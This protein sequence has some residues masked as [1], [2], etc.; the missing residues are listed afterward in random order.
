MTVSALT[1]TLLGDRGSVVSW[2]LAPIRWDH[3]HQRGAW[4]CNPELAWACWPRR[5]HK[6]GI[7]ILLCSLL[8]RQ[9]NKCDSTSFPSERHLTTQFGIAVIRKYEWWMQHS[10]FH[11]QRKKQHWPCLWL[12]DNIFPASGCGVKLTWESSWSHFHFW[13][14]KVS[15][16]E[17]AAC[18]PWCH[19][20]RPSSPQNTIKRAGR[21]QEQKGRQLHPP[22]TNVGH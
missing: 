2:C 3:L 12:K 19:C 5:K 8:G 1:G 10:L 22:N 9:Y 17:R 20:L 7:L 15:A 11:N 14:N 6:M 18:C 21:K 13:L 4:E 16:W